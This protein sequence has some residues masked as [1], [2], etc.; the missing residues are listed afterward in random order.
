MADEKAE[1]DCASPEERLAWLRARG[2]IV[3]EPA[4]R[5]LITSTGGKQF[6][7]VCIPAGDGDCVELS[8]SIGAG[9]MLPD[10]LGPGFAVGDASDETL[11]GYAAQSGQQISIS[12]L[13]AVMA[14][15][16][17]ETFRLSVPTEH[18]GREATYAYLDE[19]SALKGLPRNDR[20]TA[21]AQACGFPATCLLSGDIYIGRQRYKEGGLVENVDFNLGMIE[22][23]STWVR[24][25]VTENLEFQKMTQPEEHEAAQAGGDSKPASGQGDGYSWKDDGGDVEILVAVEKGT[26][27]KDVKVEFRKQEVR[28]IKPVAHTFK[29][30]ASVDMDGCNWTISDGA[31]VLTMEKASGGAWPKLLA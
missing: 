10:I 29:L 28:V 26:V 25:A 17:A 4:G 16:S 24:R 19:A 1:E 6:A 14:R 15:G 12:A 13:R 23:S 18:N 30:Y 5:R 11:A 27:K 9:D 31:L 3:E 8:G 2:V 20:A 7:Y 21:L 22:H